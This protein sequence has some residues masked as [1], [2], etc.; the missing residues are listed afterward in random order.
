MT[1]RIAKRTATTRRLRL[2]S[3]ARYC[4]GN[5]CLASMISPVSWS[6][7]ICNIVK[8]AMVPREGAAAIVLGTPV[9]EQTKSLL[10]KNQIEGNQVA[11]GGPFPWFIPRFPAQLL[12]RR[13]SAVIFIFP[14][15]REDILSRSHEAPLLYRGTFN[16]RSALLARW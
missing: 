8:M 11:L 9:T 16:G 15:L 4:G 7:K 5:C 13:H 3:A 12:A 2:R 10:F 14:G 6:A 1:S